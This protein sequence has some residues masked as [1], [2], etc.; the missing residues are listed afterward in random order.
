M[1][2]FTTRK[3]IRLETMKY[4]HK[5]VNPENSSITGSP[6]LPT[7]YISVEMKVSNG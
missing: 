1:D 4:I 3:N 5:P 6:K 2:K 7:S